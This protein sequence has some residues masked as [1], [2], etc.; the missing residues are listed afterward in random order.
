MQGTVWSI[1]YTYVIYMMFVICKQTQIYT[2]MHNHY[3]FLW[4]NSSIWLTLI[5]VKSLGQCT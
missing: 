4:I 3:H 1:C 5:Y 2:C